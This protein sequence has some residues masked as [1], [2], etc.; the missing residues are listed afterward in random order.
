MVVRKDS[1]AQN[2]LPECIFSTLKTETDLTKKLKTRKIANMLKTTGNI[3]KYSTFQPET[4]L[5]G[6]L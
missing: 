1:Q 5:T 3:A 4:L 6:A 2:L